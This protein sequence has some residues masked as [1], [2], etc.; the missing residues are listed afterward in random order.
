MPAKTLEQITV[1]V[2]K[3]QKLKP[4]VR[5]FSAFGDDNHAAIDAAITVLSELLDGDE[6]RER[7]G[8]GG[9]DAGPMEQVLD[10]AVRAHA[11][12]TGRTDEAVSDEGWPP[13]GEVR[14]E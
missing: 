14:P 4:T 6:V 3:L 8:A 2:E 11:W 1:E 12:M 5:R 9:M 13:G 7:F 10:T